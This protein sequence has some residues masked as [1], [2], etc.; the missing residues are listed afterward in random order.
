[1]APVVRSKKPA[2]HQPSDTRSA[3]KQPQSAGAAAE[4]GV[5][6]PALYLVATPIGNA[7]D[8]T[9]RALAVLNAVEAI[10]CE[11]SRVTARL[12]AIHG[13]RKPLM[14]C[15]DHNE[16]TAATQL[17]ARIKAGAAIA[18]VSDAGTPLISDPGFR[19]VQT[20]IEQDVT[21]V[22]VPGPSAVMAALSVAGVACERFFFAGFL[23]PRQAARLK[24]IEALATL[25]ATLVVMEAPHRL[26][27]TLADLARVLGDRPAAVTRELT[28]LFEEVRRGT[29]PE[30]AA[31]VAA[32]PPPKGEVTLVI[33]PA[34]AAAAPDPA[35]IDRMLS[36]ALVGSS[37]RAAAT[38][39]AQALDL[40]RRPLY[41]RAIALDRSHAALED[42]VADEVA[43]DGDD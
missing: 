38:A 10:A 35:D 6:A 25:P 26:A 27:A 1:M 29:L 34:A 37:P 17:V 21:V 16:R 39:V 33:G 30:L 20:C 36:E 40:P 11:D 13:I 19:L 12:L 22:P 18:F 2:R 7:R 3:R 15:H 31:A 8:I 4:A 5:L 43:E 9:L 23:P 42:D 24:A 28:K 41:A 32:G 14:P